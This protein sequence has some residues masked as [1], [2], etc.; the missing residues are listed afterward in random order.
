MNLGL[1]LLRG[2]WPTAL[3]MGQPLELEV[4]VHNVHSFPASHYTLLSITEVII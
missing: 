2:Q 1:Y 4:S 3:G